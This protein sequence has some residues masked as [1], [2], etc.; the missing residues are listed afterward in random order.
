MPHRRISLGQSQVAENKNQ[1]KNRP[2]PTDRGVWSLKTLTAGR[3]RA[4]N[5][6]SKQYQQQQADYRAIALLW[7]QKVFM[8]G[9]VLLVA[10]RFQTERVAKTGLRG[11]SPTKKADYFWLYE[12]NH[13]PS[14]CP[15]PA[16]IRGL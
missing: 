6:L 7:Q 13:T 16:T 15:T 10:I 5:V 9:R 11:A 3:A 14:K 2:R 1:N 8:A 12:K 4:S